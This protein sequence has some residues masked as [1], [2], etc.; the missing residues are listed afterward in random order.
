[1][2]SHPALANV[3]LVVTAAVLFYVTVT[4][5]KHYKIRN[6]LI[7]LL[8]GLFLLH[9]LFSGR[10]VNAAWSAGLAAFVLVFL[11]YLYSRRWMGGGDVKILSVAFLWT[12]I[13][14]ALPFALLLLLFASL[15]SAAAWLGW[16][17]S[18]QADGDARRRI[19]FAP[20]VAAALIAAFLLG[21]LRPA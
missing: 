16:V 20:S 15:H 19:A 18:H 2:V 17:G 7:L 5:L 4:D 21:C 10:W 6:E 8:F 13:D 14:C 9:T 1:M 3:V 11:V 12:G